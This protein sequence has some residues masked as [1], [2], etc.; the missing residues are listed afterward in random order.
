MSTEFE[1]HLTQYIQARRSLQK[2]KP[3]DPVLA[4]PP[5]KQQEILQAA[6]TLPWTDEMYYHNHFAGVLLAAG[7]PAADELILSWLIRLG[8][9]TYPFNSLPME[10]LVT[11]AE[12]RQSSSGFSVRL[13]TFL[14]QHHP[15]FSKLK[16]DKQYRALMHRL[17]VALALVSSDPIPTPKDA[18]TAKA[19]AWRDSLPA[20][21]RATWESLLKLASTQ[22]SGS[23]SKSY[24]KQSEALAA[25]LPQFTMIMQDIL[26]SLGRE[27]PVAVAWRGFATDMKNLL[28]ED[29]TDLLRALIW[30]CAPHATLTDSLRDASARCATKLKNIGPLCAKIAAACADTLSRQTVETSAASLSMLQSSVKHK[31][32]RKALAKAQTSMAKKAGADWSALEEQHV[33][34]HG[35]KSGLRIGSFSVRLGSSASGQ[36]ELEWCEDGGVPQRSVPAGLRVTHPDE[37][38]S[39]KTLLRDVKKTHRAQVLRLERLMCQGRDLSFEIWQEHYL[40]HP[41]VGPLTRRL[42]W[43]LGRELIHLH[44]NPATSGSLG[45]SITCKALDGRTITAST[46]MPVRLWHPAELKDD[47]IEAWQ[48]WTFKNRFIQPFQ[49]A[50][51]EVLRAE[52]DAETTE[53]LRHRGELL[54]Q[55][56]FAALC[57]D[58]GWLYSFH[59]T[60]EQFQP[61][62]HHPRANIRGAMTITEEL[63]PDGR[64]GLWLRIV[65]VQFYQ[66]THLQPLLSVPAVIYSEVMRDVGLF[67][68]ASQS[69]KDSGWRA[70]VPSAETEK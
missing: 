38:Q 46:D 61:C 40:D 69:T 68:A 6:L 64:P 23:P 32:T 47:E 3:P 34:D 50:L 49:Q 13:L 45:A 70:M 18:W 24:L 53:D 20:T 5:E 17:A 52:G 60:P 29:H 67:L 65:C 35:F 33:P 4:L 30:V 42:L 2:P 57:R 27:G 39:I 31:N 51:R 25:S 41:I 16:T 7:V 10:D 56:A 58:R 37:L 15:Q 14:R 62:I 43:R 63:Y 11:W 36:P 26:E 12:Q 66:G 55:G 44:E 59:G 22:K 21:D 1:H 28:D 48:K 54:H 9:C 19:L 8:E